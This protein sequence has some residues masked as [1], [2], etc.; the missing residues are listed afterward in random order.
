MGARRIRREQRRFD[1][2]K[3]RRENGMLKD[4]ER[5]RRD[6]RIVE[7]IKKTGK[8]PFTRHVMSWLSVA[9]DKPSTKITQVTPGQLTD[10]TAGSCVVV[11]PRRESA[12][13]GGTI[14]AQFVR[15]SPAV[16]AQCP[17]PKR[18]A[19]TPHSGGPA[20]HRPVRGTVAS[21]AGNTI[22][23]TDAGA[24]GRPAIAA[25]PPDGAEHG[26]GL[27]IVAALASEWSTHRADGGRVATWCR[28]RWD[29]P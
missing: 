2:D 3:S 16:D 17:E 10:V 5:A 28:F 29:R 13:T 21:V 4:K 1:M 22:T 15:V 6:A 18:P 9:L 19:G 14:T 23:V 7:L 26:H 25:R 20:G 24:C 27:R 8:L 12:D 11:L